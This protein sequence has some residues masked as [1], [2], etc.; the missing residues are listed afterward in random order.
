MVIIMSFYQNAQK[1]FAKFLKRLFRV[2]VIGAHNEPETGGFIVASNHLSYFDVII[3][4]AVFKR[5]IH[6]MAKKELFRVPLLGRLIRAFGAFP[7]DRKGSAV[8]SLRMSIKLLEDGEC[9]GMF[10]QGHR[11]YGR[12]LESTRSEVKG[13]VAMTAYHAKVPIVPVC[14]DTANNKVRMFKPT[15]ILIGEPVP[16]EALGFEKGGAAEYERAALN[17]FD[18]IV[19]LKRQ[20]IGEVDNG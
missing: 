19:D 17:I 12:E 4:S 10:P 2:E 7:V 5:Q 9:V 18:K 6:Y 8:S 13:G 20:G 1:H 3:L 14:I 16:Y 15:R 11:F